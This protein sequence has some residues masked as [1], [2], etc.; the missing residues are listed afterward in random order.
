MSTEMNLESRLGPFERL[1]DLV[2]A[3]IDTAPASDEPFHHLVLGPVF[4]RDVYDAMRMAMPVASDYRPMSGRSK[5][6]RTADGTPTRVKTDLFPEYIRH[7]PVEKRAIWDVVG[8]A[9]C[10]HEVQQAFVRRLAQGLRR[11]FGDDFS[12]IGMY[13]IPVLTRDFPGYRIKPHTDTQWKGI[14]VQIYLPPDDAHPHI[15]TIF[16]ERT[17]EGGLARKAQMR[18]VPNSGYAFAVGDD[19]WHSADPV[20]PEVSSRDS[21]LLTYFVDSGVVRLLRNRL[22]RAGNFLANEVRYA[23]R[24]WHRPPIGNRLPRA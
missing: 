16:H 17:P 8:R 13:P 23:S 15:G 4:P 12:S 7:L 18:F 11:R 1:R 9:L 21:I 14:T 24:R 3:S 20:G 19:T 2:A 22:K 5:S 6:N 10:A